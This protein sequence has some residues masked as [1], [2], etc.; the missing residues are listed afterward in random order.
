MTDHRL[1]DTVY[2]LPIDGKTQL[3]GLFGWPLSHTFSPAMHNAAAAAAGLNWVYVPLPVHPDDVETAVSALPALNFR[4][5]NIT[6]PHK[7]AVM[8]FLDEI[9]TGAEAIG[10]V[11][12]IV[13]ERGINNQQ[14][15]INNQQLT[16]KA[17]LVGYNTDWSGFLVDLESVGVDVAGRDCLI[18]GAGGSARAVA[19]GLATKGARVMLLA[20]RVAQ[21]EEVVARLR[22]FFPNG[23]LQAE[24]LANLADSVQRQDAPLIVNSTPL[25]MSP[26]VDGSPWPK[27]LPFPKGTFVYDLIYNP[28]QT[29]LMQQAQTAG[30]QAENGLGMLVHQG[31][32]AF[33]LWTGQQPDT[34]IMRKAI[35]FQSSSKQ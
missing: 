6:V 12:T 27:D 10:A 4:G 26:H 19:Y 11:N 9:E 7:Q 31:A 25:G 28:Q 17:R 2:R 22:P 3:I 29:K 14:S 33:H 21:A 8:P 20:R 15:T 24:S 35:Q 34:K 5:V 23:R 16:R 1:L 30:C 32:T 18:L 13:V